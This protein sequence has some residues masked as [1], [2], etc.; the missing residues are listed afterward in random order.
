MSFVKSMFYYFIH[1]LIIKLELNEKLFLHISKIWIHKADVKGRN[2]EIMMRIWDTGNDSALVNGVNGVQIVTSLLCD[3][4]LLTHF[5]QVIQVYKRNI[6][7]SRAHKI[8]IHYLLF[9]KNVKTHQYQRTLWSHPTALLW[10]LHPC[11]SKEQSV[12]IKL[13]R[14]IASS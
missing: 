3:W 10:S 8:R 9:Y 2:Q 1:L 12:S 14:K 5:R 11:N 6:I 4:D 7:I 13:Y